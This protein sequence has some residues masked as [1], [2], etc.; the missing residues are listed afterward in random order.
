MNREFMQPWHSL[1]LEMI[2]IGEI[3]QRVRRIG[4]GIQHY[5]K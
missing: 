5:A 4:N 3:G 1:F 2:Q